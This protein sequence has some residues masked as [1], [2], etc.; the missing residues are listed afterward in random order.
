M[1]PTT[2]LDATHDH[3]PSRA[4]NRGVWLIM[5]A[6]VL[7]GTVGVSTQIL[8]HVSAANPLSVGFFR[9]G[10]AAPTLVATCLA[11][12]GGRALHIK[13]RDFVIMALIGVMLALYQACFF[14]AIALVGVTIATLVT[15]CAAPVIVALL[16]ALVFR[17]R[18]S[19]RVLLALLL[20][21]VGIALVVGFRAD[22]QHAA[23]NPVGVALAL[24]SALGYAVV[25]LAG[26][27]L[28]ARY[29]ALQINAV[30]FTMGALALLPLALASGFVV[31][32]PPQGWL[33]LLYL[34]LVPTALAYVLFLM[35]MRSTPATIASIVTLLEPLTATALAWILFGERLGPP[36]L[37]GAAL[38]LSAL[39]ALARPARLKK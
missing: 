4:T 25:A 23:P 28:A 3:T 20:A 26:R 27:A 11:R 30:G 15:L 38:L 5:L 33:L 2:I 10:V 19:P 22:A 1:R 36:G 8:Y 35:G 14:A 31:S 32:Y 24:G 13:R 17:E 34:G 18:P 9:L 12:L 7:W 16:S 39:V 37:V 6:A 29:D 21:L